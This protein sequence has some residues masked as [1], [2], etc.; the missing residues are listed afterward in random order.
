[1]EQTIYGLK[2][3]YDQ[4][5][6]RV[7]ETACEYYN[8]EFIKSNKQDMVEAGKEIY[9]KN[10]L[11]K[12]EF[13]YLKDHEIGAFTLGVK[14][15]LID[16]EIISMA[17]RILEEMGTPNLTVK[18]NTSENSLLDYLNYLDVDYE[19]NSTTSEK[20]SDDVP[21]VFEITS[22]LKDQDIIVCK[23]KQSKSEV[24]ASFTINKDYLINILEEEANFKESKNIDVYI[25]ASS[26]EEILTAVRL[27]QDLRWSEITTEMDYQNKNL[28]EQLNEAER[29][30]ARMVIKLNRED[31][32]KGLISVL[33]S[34]T[35][36]ETK[37]DENEILDYI[38]SNL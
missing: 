26:L 7:F 32:K 13:Y 11:E 20:I 19:V 14:T 4:Y 21:L 29:L 18:I 25:T 5:I 37:V 33:D 30:N 10:K 23:G 6:T 16:A 38:I 12:A 17:Y 22:K 24:L 3:K 35:K 8:Y 9:L 36:E 28:E 2:A 1:M 27:I 31:L 34:L 15:N